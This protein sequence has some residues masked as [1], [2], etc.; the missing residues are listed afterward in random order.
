MPADNQNLLTLT[1]EIVA[2]HL[3]NNA[4]SVADLPAVITN[5][6]DALAGLGA[7]K[8]ENVPDA[9]KR[10]ISVRASIQPEHLISMID[11]KPYKMLKRHLSLN[12]YTPETYRQT[13]GLPR[14]YPM[15]AATYSETRRA[16]AHKSGLGRKPK[17]VLETT[18]APDERKPRRVSLKLKI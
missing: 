13:F 7:A 16:L 15:V 18:S 6:H 17:E 1:A 2:S 5:V 10:A 4:V 8:P 9:P 11:G 3:A 12:G 14:D